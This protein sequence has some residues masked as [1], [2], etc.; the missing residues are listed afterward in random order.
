MS[1][2]EKK[3]DP[4]MLESDI[5]QFVEVTKVKLS[6][7]LEEISQLRLENDQIQKNVRRTQEETEENAA[8]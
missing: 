3:L 8:L 6:S 1:G 2:M 4:L 5:M 7:L